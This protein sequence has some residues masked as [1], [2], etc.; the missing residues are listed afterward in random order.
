MSV[1]QEGMG[2]CPGIPPLLWTAFLT[3]A[4][5][6]I[7]F[8]QLR[9]WA[10]KMGSKTFTLAPDWISASRQVSCPFSVAFINAVGP[11]ALPRGFLHILHDFGGI[12]LNLQR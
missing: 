1:C 2:V 10:V 11:F 3:H 12:I 6:N 8:P 4:C 5:E 9:L 7:T